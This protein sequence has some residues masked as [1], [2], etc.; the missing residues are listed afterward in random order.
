MIVNEI[1]RILLVFL[2]ILAGLITTGAGPLNGQEL[3]DQK[4]S[5][6]S[7]GQKYPGSGTAQW[8]RGDG[9]LGEMA[10]KMPKRPVVAGLPMGSLRTEVTRL[11]SE[12]N[13]APLQRV[14]PM[15]IFPRLIGEISYVQKAYIYYTMDRVSKVDLLFEV[16][17]DPKIQTGQN[18]FDFYKEL[19]KT[20]TRHYGQPTNTTSYVHPNFSYQLVALE[21]G[22]A[23]YF[24][25]WENVDDLR[26]LLSLKG[27]G[28]K[29]NFS[30]TYQYLPLFK[31]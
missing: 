12:K 29:I 4:I 7:G 26:I 27:K 13:I 8:T 18:L 17:I 15:D 11:F 24:D 10:F 30:L 5:I 21:T 25:Y 14:A 28:E 1:E 6:D 20:L 9:I 19:R 23:Y 22:N 31:D 16:P 3:K 2:F